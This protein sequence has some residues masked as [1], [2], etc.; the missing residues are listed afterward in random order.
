VTNGGLVLIRFGVL[1]SY[2]PDHYQ[3]AE[4]QASAVP[5]NRPAATNV[6]SIYP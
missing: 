5:L 6:I 1:D 3:S 2:T 4:I